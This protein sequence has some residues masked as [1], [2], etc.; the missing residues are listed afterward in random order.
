MTD[1]NFIVMIP[2]V[3]IMIGVLAAFVSC[4]VMLYFAFFSDE[5]PHIIF[6]RDFWIDVLGRNVFDCKDDYL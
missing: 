1:E 2:S 3:V 6:L 5:V 4:T